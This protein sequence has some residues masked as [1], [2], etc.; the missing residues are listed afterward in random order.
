MNIRFQLF[1]GAVGTGFQ[2]EALARGGGIILDLTRMDKIL[3]INGEN[4]SVTVEV[5]VIFGKLIRL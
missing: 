5:G 4:L 2:A 3:D 1:L